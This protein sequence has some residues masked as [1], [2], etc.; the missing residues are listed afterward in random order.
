MASAASPTGAAPAVPARDPSSSKLRNS[1]ATP[2]PGAGDGKSSIASAADGQPLTLSRSARAWA[3]VKWGVSLP[4]SLIAGAYRWCRNYI[5]APARVLSNVSVPV[6]RSGWFGKYTE[7]V[8]VER[9]LEEGLMTVDKLI[10]NKV[11]TPAEAKKIGYGKVKVEYY[12]TLSL[13]GWVRNPYSKDIPIKRAIAERYL[14]PVK[15]VQDKHIDLKDAIELKWLKIEDAIKEGLIKVEEAI[16]Q[17]LISKEKATK[18]GL[19]K[20]AEPVKK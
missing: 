1:G 15:A 4:F 3:A 17:N 10:E 7:S 8:S 19:L 13:G 12:P 5:W 20:V 11:I 9:V 16:K 6:E 2:P 14:T 18:A